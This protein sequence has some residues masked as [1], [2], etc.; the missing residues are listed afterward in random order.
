MT[1]AQSEERT[2]MCTQQAWPPWPALETGT[3][4]VQKPLCPAC[5][6]WSESFAWSSSARNLF[7]DYHSRSSLLGVEGLRCHVVF[8]GF[9]PAMNI[10]FSVLNNHSIC[11]TLWVEPP[12]PNLIYS[13]TC[14]IVICIFLR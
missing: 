7:A 4:Q 9:P 10:L 5:F 6:I 8:L 12:L 14:V 3:G 13:A 1:S 11:M 2:V